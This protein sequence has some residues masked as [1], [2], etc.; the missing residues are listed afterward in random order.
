MTTP[1]SLAIVFI[2]FVVAASVSW[3]FRLQATTFVA[4]TS[5]MAGHGGGGSHSSSV[6][7]APGPISAA[8]VPGCPRTCFCNSLSRIVYCSRR[9]L[10]AVP[11]TL[12]VATLQLNLNG[13]RF[14]STALLRS[15][16]S[17]PNLHASSIEHL[18][19]SDCGIETVQVSYQ[20]RV[21]SACLPR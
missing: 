7:P 13:N 11:M 8:S 19:L 5:A 2:R 16:F 1:R 21:A 12:P 10:D 6:I 20:N 14:R 9:G 4:A 18:Y 15:N 17:S 3:A